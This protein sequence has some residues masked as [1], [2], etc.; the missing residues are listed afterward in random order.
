MKTLQR[1]TRPP[2]FAD[3]GDINRN[4][5]F[6]AY[7]QHR[8]SDTLTRSNFRSILSS[9][10]G[11]SDTVLIIRDSHWAVGWVEAIYIHESDQA[12][13]T[14]ADDILTALED[15]PI[16]NATDFSDLEWDAACKYWESMSVSDRVSWLQRYEFNVSIFAAR[17]SELPEGLDNISELAS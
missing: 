15:Y 11:E 1:Y 16:V 12:K 8:D 17:R 6:V 7:G 9:L 3:F 5:Y 13:L 10:G 2:N 4:E 14:I